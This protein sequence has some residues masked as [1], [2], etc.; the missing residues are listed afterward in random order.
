MRDRRDP[1]KWPFAIGLALGL[2]LAVGLWLPRTWLNFLLAPQDSS[3]ATTGPAGRW[4]VLQPPP[5]IEV[6]TAR[7]PR[8]DPP[9]RPQTPPPHEDPRWWLAGFAAGARADTALFAPAAA[10]V[11]T[12]AQVL[13]ALGLGQ[14]FMTAARPDS[15][16]AARLI[17]L[18]A[19]DAL[20]FDALKPLLLQ[21]GRAERY[22][23]IMSKAADMYD[24]PLA[25]E[26]RVPD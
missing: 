2:T 9:A 26:I 23:D 22:A 20:A 11:D 3:R 13:A 18:Q 1:W 8:P 17:L 21:M 10:P 24:E 25:Q 12:V 15:V 5:V 4:L 14:D 6:Q 7:D 19:H 16:L